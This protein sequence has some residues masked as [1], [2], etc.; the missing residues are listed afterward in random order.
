MADDPLAEA[1]FREQFPWT[2]PHVPNQPQR[3]GP[4]TFTDA[5]VAAVRTAA[6]RDPWRSPLVPG[7]DA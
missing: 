3:S 6:E 4:R 2:R 5:E 7:G 1:P